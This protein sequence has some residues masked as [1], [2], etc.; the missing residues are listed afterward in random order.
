MKM[1]LINAEELKSNL[2][3]VIDPFVYR[4]VIATVDEE[5]EIEAIP[6]KWILDHFCCHGIVHTERSM[7]REA[8]LKEVIRRWRKENESNAYHR[9]AR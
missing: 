3:W 4:D 6:V 1:R 9:N 8:V 7:V 5:K 2:D